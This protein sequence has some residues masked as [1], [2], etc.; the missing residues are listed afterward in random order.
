[1]CG[2][3]RSA[4]R[5]ERRS[6]HLSELRCK[7]ERA[8]NATS[9]PTPTPRA[10]LSQAFFNAL[11]PAGKAQVAA[12]ADID[13]N[14]IGN[15]Y[16]PP[17]GIWRAAGGKAGN[18]ARAA[19]GAAQRAAAA[20]GAGRPATAAVADRMTGK[21]R[22]HDDVAVQTPAESELLGGADDGVHAGASAGVAPPAPAPASG[23][24]GVATGP[25]ADE[26]GAPAAGGLDDWAPMLPPPGA[27]PQPRPI[28]HFTASPR[29]IVCCVALTMGSDE[30][31]RNVTSLGVTQGR[32]FWYFV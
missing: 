23:G 11:S 13:P 9:T 26:R 15:V 21:K 5:R 3:D 29:P 24:A 7:H 18:A 28:V 4:G 32:D 30:L 10:L 14:K 6:D 19:A 16:P 22:R 8:V 20:V 25:A 17:S 2:W 12:F 27:P 1:M 31:V